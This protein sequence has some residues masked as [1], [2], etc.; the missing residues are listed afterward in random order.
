MEMSQTD[1]FARPVQGRQFF[2][3]VIR[4]NLDLGRPEHVSV[5]FAQR[6]TRRT[7]PPSRGYRS[8]II[9]A[10]VNPSLHAHFK[11]SHV[12]QYFKQDRALRTETTIN[13][14]A[15]VFVNKG[16][17]H[18][19][20]LKDIGQQVNRKLLE[21]ERLSHDCVLSSDA[22]QRLQVAT[23]EGSQRAPALRLGDPR[24]MAIMQ[25]LCL[26]A[27]VP[28]GFRNRDLRPQVAALW[29]LDPDSY[30]SSRMSYDLRRLRLKGLISRIGTS[31]RYSVTTYG[32]KVAL[33]YSKLHLR[34]LRPVA[35]AIRPEPNL[36]V[37]PS[38]PLHRA[39]DQVDR[40]LNRLWDQAQF[41]P[42]PAATA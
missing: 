34:L 29:G 11:H 27:H 8:R 14:P 41:Q 9:T 22:L 20:H 42:P 19:G 4:E 7:P 26:F 18:L 24:V 1:V 10:G 17:K 31:H 28:T 2:E 23:L 21:H 12:K 37:R 3:A 16:L 5:A 15:D 39:F 35:D 25:A 33:F 13:D 32:L 30:R 6:P 38:S 36:S 40:Q